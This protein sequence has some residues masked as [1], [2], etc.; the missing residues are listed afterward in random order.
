MIRAKFD[1][2]G[3]AKNYS[4]ALAHM[5]KLSGLDRRTIGRAEAGVILKTAAYRTKVAP[6]S[7]LTIA[8]RV[9]TLRGLGLTSGKEARRGVRVTVNAGKRAAYGR[10]WARKAGSDGKWQLVLGDNYSEIRRHFSDD[11][12]NVA[13][14]AARE[15]KKK[16]PE[17]VK[18]AKASAGIARKGW[19]QIADSLGIDLANVKG[20]P[21]LSP[22]AIA[23]ARAAKAR[24]GKDR[25]N[26][27]SREEISTGKWFAWLIYS[28]PYGRKL[29]L[30]RT[31]TLIIAGRVKFFAKAVEKGYVGSLADSA[32]LFPGWV[33]KGG[34]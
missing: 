30:D 17:G 5:A 1:L 7:E 2:R 22:A 12:Y 25:E 15:A 6:V 28:V 23:K 4:S 18:K 24:G 32:K 20:G 19:I 27:A 13:M 29:G 31:L 3:A 11:V 21:P 33:V 34:Q 14:E 9:R 26:G 8:G 16:V 10:V